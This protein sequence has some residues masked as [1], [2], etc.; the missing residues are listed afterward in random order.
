MVGARIDPRS[1]RVESARPPRSCRAKSRH[2]STLRRAHGCLVFGQRPK[3][4]LSACTA[5]EGLDTNGI[6]RLI[7]PTGPRRRSEEHKSEIQLLMRT[8][9]AVLRL[10]KKTTNTH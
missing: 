6:R 3:I 2:P 10:H 1:E 7:R 5:V 9:Y 4:I 8:T